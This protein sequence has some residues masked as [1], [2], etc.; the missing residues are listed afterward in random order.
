MHL[1]VG[2]NDDVYFGFMIIDTITDNQIINDILIFLYDEGKCG[3]APVIAVI[4]KLHP[5]VSENQS[6]AFGQYLYVH[7]LITFPSYVEDVD[8]KLIR[9]FKEQVLNGL[10]SKAKKILIQHGDYLTYLKNNKRSLFKGGVKKWLKNTAAIIAP[11]CAIV[12]IILTILQMIDTKK[13]E[14]IQRKQEST[15]KTL[16]SLKEQFQIHLLP[17]DSSKEK[18]HPKRLR[19]P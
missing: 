12:T 10:T 13:I 3:Y 6:I 19:F 1:F 9:L 4:K 17:Q 2:V 18:I 8:G 5:N 11:I 15:A 14:A 7:E 16:D